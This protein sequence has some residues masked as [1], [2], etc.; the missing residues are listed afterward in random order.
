MFELLPNEVIELIFKYLISEYDIINFAKIN[1][2]MYLFF[3]TNN[4]I[5]FPQIHFD[6]LPFDVCLTDNGFVLT[7]KYD[8]LYDKIITLFDVDIYLHFNS[9]K[10]NYLKNFNE[11]KTLRKFRKLKQLVHYSDN[12]ILKS[13]NLNFPKCYDFPQSLESFTSD[14]YQF[15]SEKLL[16]SLRLIVSKNVPFGN[17]RLDIKI[18]L[19]AIKY[20]EFDCKYYNIPDLKS[21]CNLHTL[22]IKNT[23]NKI[24]SLPDKLEV[25]DGY[26]GLY[27]IPDT[28][29]TLNMFILIE[30]NHNYLSN[31]HLKTL[32]LDIQSNN[33]YI[34]ENSHV[35]E[36]NIIYID[37]QFNDHH[38]VNFPNVKLLNIEIYD[39]EIQEG[40][41]IVNHLLKQYIELDSLGITNNNENYNNYIDIYVPK[42]KIKKFVSYHESKIILVSFNKTYINLRYEAS[43]MVYSKIF[44]LTTKEFICYNNFPKITTNINLPDLEYLG[45]AVRRQNI[46]LI[47]DVI[48]QRKINHLQICYDED[49]DLS[50]FSCHTFI[51]G[52][53]KKTKSIYTTLDHSIINEFTLIEPP[54][55]NM[56]LNANNVKLPKDYKIL[57]LHNTWLLQNLI[58]D[59]L[60]IIILDQR[61]KI[62]KCNLMN[63]KEIHLSKRHDISVFTFSETCQIVF[64]D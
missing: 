27:E 55:F 40:S 50:S 46:N 4:M 56:I 57:K 18:N 36:L 53:Y 22:K 38:F 43:N 10:Q 2:Q 6:K 34:L 29:H 14:I 26:N 12:K 54:N 9:K 63:V 41:H 42:L 23:G 32:Y 20:L 35:T 15:N 1:K 30:I 47:I 49:C 59:K 31:T 25:F 33:P 5:T 58:H 17:E 45:L 51:L 62:K 24:L 16:K 52:G 64:T 8:F 48:Q 21:M 61:C 19:L 39:Y 13:R 3:K 44:P 28:I 60:E 7:L 11:S 37:S